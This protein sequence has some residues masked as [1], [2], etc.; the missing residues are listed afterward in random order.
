MTMEKRPEFRLNVVSEASRVMGAEQVEARDWYKE[1]L[2]TLPEMRVEKFAVTGEGGWEGRVTSEGKV[3]SITGRHFDIEGRKVI[4]NFTWNQPVIVQ[5]SEEFIDSEGKANKISGMVLLLEDPNGRVFVSV[6]QEP[7]VEAQVVNGREIHP[8][9]RTP[10]QTSV[11]KL[12]QLT[13]GN[14]KVDP[15][16]SAVL[17]ALKVDNQD[18]SSIVGDIPWVPVDTDG[19]RIESHVL[20]GILKLNEQ[21]VKLV[22]E[23]IPQGRFF[24]RNQLNALPLNGHLHIA[25]SVA[26]ETR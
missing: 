25:L 10:F 11:E 5:R 3:E 1:Q 22:S 24:S 18:L 13:A 21:A 26:S 9:V 23:K 20:Y 6:G 19:N 8:V 17:S 4:T 12:Q 2:N 7:G 15:T 14:E 16:L